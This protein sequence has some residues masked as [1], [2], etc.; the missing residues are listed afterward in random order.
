MHNCIISIRKVHP[1]KVQLETY[2]M[3][4]KFSHSPHLALF[5]HFSILYQII[6]LFSIPSAHKFHSSN[7]KCHL[8]AKL[9]SSQAEPRI[10]VLKLPLSLHPSVYNSRCTTT[11][12]RPKFPSTKVVFYA[13]NLTTAAAVDKLFADVIKD[14]GKINIVVNTIGAVLKKPITAISEEEYDTLFA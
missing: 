6:K 2:L 14:F 7:S 12:P 3:E 8:K 10:L 5:E 1:F 13:A 4:Y 9:H 11:H